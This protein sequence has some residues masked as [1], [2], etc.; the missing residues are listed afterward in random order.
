MKFTTLSLVVGNEACNAK[1]PFCVARQTFS[2]TPDKYVP[3]YKHLE[4]ACRLAQSC[5]VTTCLL[6]GKG[7]PTLFPGEVS[8]FI[9]VASK[10]FPIIELQTNGI[11]F[12]QE[13]DKWSKIL[14]EWSDAGLTTMA[15]SVVHF[16]D[17]KNQIIYCGEKPQRRYPHLSDTLD[18]IHEFGISI[19]LSCIGIKDYIDSLEKLETLVQ[20]ANKHNVEQVTWRPVAVPDRSRNDTVSNAARK[21]SLPEN[22]I[23]NISQ[24][25]GFRGT[26]LLKLPHGAE[27]YDIPVK[28]IDGNVHGQ[29]LCLSN[30]LTM[31]PDPE[32][33]RQ[34]IYVN[35]HLRY[36]WTHEGAIIL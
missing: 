28:D 5:G 14:S 25:I 26:L 7:E 23:Q 6:T 1:C 21:M 15:L 27:I 24:R 4:T 8:H 10:Y 3:N 20:Y 30:C 31:T 29:N 36:D 2:I 33:I 11:V 18:F 32:S 34:L 19:R 16:E 17:H 13:K 35:A 9:D 22:V 12:T